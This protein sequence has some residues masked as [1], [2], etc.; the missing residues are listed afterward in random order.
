MLGTLGWKPDPVMILGDCDDRVGCRARQRIP[1][2]DP[3]QWHM[4]LGDLNSTIIAVF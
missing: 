3:I 4:A 1:D 2:E